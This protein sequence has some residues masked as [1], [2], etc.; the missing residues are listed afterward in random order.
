MGNPKKGFPFR[1]GSLF[2]ASNIE[3]IGTPVYKSIW[4]IPSSFWGIQNK[5]ILVCLKVRLHEHSRPSWG[6]QN[7]LTKK[8]GPIYF[9][10]DFSRHPS[11]YLKGRDGRPLACVRN[12]IRKYENRVQKFSVPKIF[13]SDS[14]GA[15]S[16]PYGSGLA[17]FGM[18][19][20]VF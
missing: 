4:G 5:I 14:H 1:V 2:S 12:F 13:E 3:Q 15:H 11:Q 20:E 7:S 16:E 18:Q 9:V 17:P 6:H 8:S 19:S 10:N